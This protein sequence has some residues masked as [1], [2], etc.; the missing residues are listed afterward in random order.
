M[1]LYAA[2]CV[3]LVRLSPISQPFQCPYCAVIAAHTQPHD[4][5]RGDVITI[6]ETVMAH[7]DPVLTAPIKAMQNATPGLRRLPPN[8]CMFVRGV[9]KK[10]A[11]QS[12]VYYAV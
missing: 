10:R 5:G 9:L 3:Q 7:S 6:A 4:P 1:A 2:V 12:A 8:E 11:I